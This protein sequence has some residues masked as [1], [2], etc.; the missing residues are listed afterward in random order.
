MSLNSSIK[1][2]CWRCKMARKNPLLFNREE[3]Q[4]LHKVFLLKDSRSKKVIAIKQ[5][6]GMGLDVEEINFVKQKFEEWEADHKNDL[7]WMQ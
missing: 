1:R 2:G 5:K 3:Y 7:L 6:R 4:F